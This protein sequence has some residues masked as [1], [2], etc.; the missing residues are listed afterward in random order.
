MDKIRKIKI[1][2]IDFGEA[3][4]RHSYYTSSQNKILPCYH[5]TEKGC[6]FLI[7]GLVQEEI[8]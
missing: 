2:H 1:D 7:L 3:E 5:I 6:Q 4:F 8:Q